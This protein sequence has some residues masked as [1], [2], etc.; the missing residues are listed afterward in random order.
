MKH[1][2]NH[3]SHKKSMMLLLALFRTSEVFYCLIPPKYYD[4]N[5]YHLTG[6]QEIKQKEFVKLSK[7]IIFLLAKRFF[8]LKVY[9][10]FV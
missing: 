5:Q 8:L 1:R 7:F 9:A 6:K 3:A 2:K 10:L 4:V